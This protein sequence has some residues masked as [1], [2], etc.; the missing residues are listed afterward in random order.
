[1]FEWVLGRRLFV[2]SVG[3]IGGRKREI[4]D[5]CAC[6]ESGWNSIA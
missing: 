1:M 5:L 2:G 6:F 3:W 4:D